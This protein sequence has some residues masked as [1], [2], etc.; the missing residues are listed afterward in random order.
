MGEAGRAR[1]SSGLD[2]IQR[3][4]ALGPSRAA[5]NTGVAYKGHLVAGEGRRQ[6]GVVVAG[7]G[8]DRG[9]GD[10]ASISLPYQWTPLAGCHAPPPPTS[11]GPLL[12]PSQAP[13]FCFSERR[14]R[15]PLR[16]AEGAL[17]RPQ[18]P[19][20]M[21]P[22]TLSTLARPAEGPGRPA[23]SPPLPQHAPRRSFLLRDKIFMSAGRPSLGR[24]PA[25]S[26]CSARAFKEQDV[27]PTL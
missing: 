2:F 24:L 14:P 23:P 4:V 22:P 20:D 16:E 10:Q 11:P 3:G 15:A 21:Q 25:S 27:F 12:G 19:S 5:E 18:G 13:L 26:V 6:E 1:G 8:A 17:Q 7:Q 9:K